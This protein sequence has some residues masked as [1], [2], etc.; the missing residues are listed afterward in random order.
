VPKAQRHDSSGAALRNS[1]TIVI[2]AFSMI[3]HIDLLWHMRCIIMEVNAA[4]MASYRFATRW[5]EGASAH[6]YDEGRYG[7]NE[8]LPRRQFL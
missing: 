6:D 4:F 8:G 2:V 1:E 7:A 5:Q 3:P